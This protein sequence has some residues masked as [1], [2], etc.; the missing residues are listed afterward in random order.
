MSKFNKKNVF[1]FDIKD[2][3]NLNLHEGTTVYNG[4]MGNRKV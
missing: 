2:E 1:I 3:Y 4:K